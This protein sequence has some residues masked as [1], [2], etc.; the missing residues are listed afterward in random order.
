MKFEPNCRKVVKK[1]DFS[2]LIYDSSNGVAKITMN[3]ASNSNAIDTPM[4]LELL[5][6]FTMAENASEIKVVVLTASGK[7]FS[8]G[9][10]LKSMA[11]NIKNGTNA[12]VETVRALCELVLFI[13]KMHVCLIS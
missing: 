13:K 10:D 7:N 6:A 4:A 5:E 1:M 11:E 9:G 12:T 8:S 3:S 2:K